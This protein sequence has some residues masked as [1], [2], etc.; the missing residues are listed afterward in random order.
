MSSG[1]CQVPSSVVTFEYQKGEIGRFSSHYNVCIGVHHNE[2]VA[3]LTEPPIQRHLR[4]YWAHDLL[5]R[6]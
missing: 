6:F 4:R 2:I 5:V 1:R 3:T